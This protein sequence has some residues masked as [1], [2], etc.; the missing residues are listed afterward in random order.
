MSRADSMSPKRRDAREGKMLGKLE[1]GGAGRV[2]ESVGEGYLPPHQVDTSRIEAGK[3]YALY[4]AM[5]KMDT[6]I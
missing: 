3:A 6:G 2:V 5:S 4:R 1:Q